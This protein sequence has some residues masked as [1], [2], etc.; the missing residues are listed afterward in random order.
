MR[1]RIFKL[2]V[3]ILIVMMTSGM[4]VGCSVGA[5]NSANE[6][7]NI[8]ITGSSALLPLIEQS[9]EK[10][11]ESNPNDIINAQAGG[12][13]TGLTQVLEGTADIGNS[14]VFAESK[15]TKEQSSELVDHKVVAQGFGVVVNKNSN[16]KNLT[17]K[18][19]QDIFSGKVKNFKEIGGKDLEILV[20][21]RP[22]SS[23]S[24]ETFVEKILN[25]NKDLENDS[26]GIV[27]DSNGAVLNTIKQNEGAISYI[28]LSYM[29][30]KEAKESLGLV[31]I[32]E[33][34]ATS[35]NIKLDKYNFW[36]WGHM[37]TKGEAKGLSK[38]FIDFIDSK[39]NAENVDSLGL[40]RGS[41]IK[42]NR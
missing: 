10:F 34:E 3:V 14:D 24:R 11:N 41:E 22:A 28:A 2:L 29:T 39:E 30:N 17:K 33:K 19:I 9:I 15:L 38:R 21:H 32:D 31:K 23:G 25:G 18:Q 4:F 1:K 12:S 8:T 35:Q 26:I 40:I 16:I 36:S 27:Q 5:N 13:G 37:Y 6:G 7:E 42:S 20:I